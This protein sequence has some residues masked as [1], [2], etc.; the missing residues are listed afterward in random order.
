M[1]KPLTEDAREL[2][3]ADVIVNPDELGSVL[4]WLDRARWR[5]PRAVRESFESLERSLAETPMVNMDECYDA[6]SEPLKYGRCD[7]CG[8]PCD[9][10]GCTRHPLAI[11]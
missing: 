1:P 9:E 5:M 7:S 3:L 6:A 11:V 2:K 8:A 4:K 10:N